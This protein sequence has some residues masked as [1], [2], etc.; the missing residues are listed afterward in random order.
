[1]IDFRLGLS[2]WCYFWVSNAIAKSISGMSELPIVTFI[3]V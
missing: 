1:M 2:S 3:V